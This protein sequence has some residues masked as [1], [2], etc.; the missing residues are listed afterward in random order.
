MKIHCLLFFSL[1]ASA[2]CAADSLKP[3][4]VA[5]SG[6]AKQ[7]GAELKPQQPIDLKAPIVTGSRGFTKIAVAPGLALGLGPHTTAAVTV[8][9]AGTNGSVGEV[10]LI[11]GQAYCAL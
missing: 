5:V 7:A 8:A 2:V 6:S 1:A 3:V 11:S 10:E 4:A 9:Q